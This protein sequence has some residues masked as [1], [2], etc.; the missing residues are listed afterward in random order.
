MVS[1]VTAADNRITAACLVQFLDELAGKEP[2]VRQKANARSGHPR[3]NFLKAALNKRTRPSI[4]TRISRSE[5]AMPKLLAMSFEAENGM[6]GRTTFGFGIVTQ[7]SALLFAVEGQNARVQMKNQG[8]S[9]IGH[10]KQFAS[11]L[12]VEPR[13]LPNGIRR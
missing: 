12:I 11:K 2:R 13:N 1:L 4:G 10:R 6:V 8:T 7:A 9:G 3:G 5:G